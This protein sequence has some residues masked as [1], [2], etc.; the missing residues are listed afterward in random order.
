MNLTADRAMAQARELDAELARGRYGGPLHG[1]PWGVKDSVSAN[2]RAPP[3][4]ARKPF[5]KRVID[6]DAEVVQRLTRAGAVLVAK[7]TTVSLRL[8][9]SGFGGRPTAHG[10]RAE[11]QCSS[12][13][14]ARPPPQAWSRSRSARI[15]GGSILSR[16]RFDAASSAFAHIWQGESSR[17]CGRRM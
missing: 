11:G 12:A 6:E 2:R 9:I 16:P 15:P 7:L 10:I 17:A 5:E 1:L 3:P 8:A 4:G 13:V 14:P